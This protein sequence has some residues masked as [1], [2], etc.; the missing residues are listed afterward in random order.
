MS[1]VFDDIDREHQGPRK[2]GETQFSYL[3]RSG[4]VEAGRVRSLVEDWI[5]RYPESDLTALVARLRSTID[6]AHHSAFFELAVHELLVRTGHTIVAVEPK[7][8]N[9]NR[10]PDFLVEA[11]DGERFYVEVVTSIAQT[12][13]EMAAEKRLNDAVC[14]V[15][16]ADA[17]FHFLDVQ[18]EGKPKEQV[19]AKAL[20]PALA[21]WIAA[22]PVTDAVKDQPPFVYAEHGMT[23]TIGAFL[24]NTPRREAGGAIGLQNMEP[25]WGTPGDGIRESVERKASRY[26]DLD[27]PYV[28][29]VNAMSD[30]KS[31]EDAID[32]MFGSPCVV[33]RRYEDGRTETAESRNGDGVWQGAN[34]PRKKGLS[35]ILSTERLAPWSVGQRRARLIRNPWATRPLPPIPLGI[36]ELNP[37]DGRLEKTEGQPFR[38]LFNLPAS[39]PED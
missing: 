26:G 36:D 23:L 22:L 8:P 24:R 28:V 20:R 17:E 32:A 7:V 27:L 18:I 6:A 35:A 29:A 5:T 13:Q 39:W 38:E 21:N 3:N 34:G 19:S 11:P 1:L 15:D 37:I 12:P 10:R 2:A 4:R 14:I 25:F 31:E 30:Y 16:K 9:S 33:V